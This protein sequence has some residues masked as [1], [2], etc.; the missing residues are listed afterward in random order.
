M[1][2]T[3][4]PCKTLLRY[5]PAGSGKSVVYSAGYLLLVNVTQA[6]TGCKGPLLEIKRLLDT[7]LFKPFTLFIQKLYRKPKRSSKG[8]R[9][10][11]HEA[12]FQETLRQVMAGEADHL[13]NLTY[14]PLI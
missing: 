1:G 14:D 2:Q 8:R 7:C 11:N 6:K 12:I 13:S 10:V 3:T 4:F 5:K 9:K